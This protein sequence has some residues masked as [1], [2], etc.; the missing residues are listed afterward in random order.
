MADFSVPY[1]ETG[2]GFIANTARELS[3]WAALLRPYSTNAW[4]AILLAVFVSGPVLCFFTIQYHQ[5]VSIQ[6]SYQISYKI[7]LNQG[8]IF[9]HSNE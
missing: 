8:I 9:E 4:I 2:A 5:P 3:K 7:F 1:Y 6:R